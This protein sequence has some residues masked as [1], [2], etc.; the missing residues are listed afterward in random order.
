[1]NYKLPFWSLR[2]KTRFSASDNELK[3]VVL[4]YYWLR[5]LF[6]SCYLISNCPLNYDFNSRKHF[7]KGWVFFD[8]SSILLF[9]GW[10]L[11]L[12]LYWIDM[13]LW[14]ITSKFSQFKIGIKMKSKPYLLKSNVTL[15][16]SSYS[17][18][19][20]I[21]FLIVFSNGIITWFIVT[22]H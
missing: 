22:H 5:F 10:W 4:G 19:F 7:P 2:L 18:E 11:W 6:L 16:S 21:N 3:P 9:R 8:F 15:I 20:F 17:P 13:N 1:M 12:Q 14:L